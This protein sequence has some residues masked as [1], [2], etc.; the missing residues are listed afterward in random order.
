MKR[1]SERILTTHVGSLA[2][3]IELLD[4][5]RARE[6]GQP[7]DAAAYA[8]VVRAA[9]A[10]V[11][12]RQAGAGLD[13]VSDGEQGKV[14]FVSY[15]Q[16]RL[17]GFEPGAGSAVRAPSW[18]LEAAAFPE[19]YA[20]YF[21]KYRAA[22]SP[23]KP[24]VCTAPVRYVGQAAVRADIA[25]LQAALSGVA[26]EE[27]FMAATIPEG[28][29]RNA[30]YPTQDEYDEA[31]CDALRE[32]YRAILDAGLV[33]QIDDPA[34]VEILNEN[35]ARELP[36]RRRLAD[37]HIE[38]LNYALRGLPEERIRLHVCYGLNH[39]PRI[40]DA[41]LGE[42]V[43]FMLRVRAGAYSFE[44]A[45]P[46]HMHE[47][48]VWEDTRLPAGKMLIP[49]LL[50]HATSFVEHPLLIADQIETYARLVGREN[51]MAGADCGFSSRA[52]YKPEIQP[53]IV[54]AKFEALAEGARLAT[55]RLWARRD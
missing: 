22:I 12:R 34:L 52:T 10:D 53:R 46:R 14:N 43:G 11:V 48:R 49:G 15:I 32:E 16:E 54:W 8:D 23:V 4:V 17:V 39:G 9:V 41:P 31:V 44:V 55:R 5:M 29:G 6:H 18:S 47:W 19:Y 38:K 45:N 42:V 1:S 26:V 40:H 30:F 36:A 20:D 25:N 7:Y 21:A 37:Q 33:L 28:V 24:L 51:V 13:V 2:R 27:A 35:P 50:S 3:P